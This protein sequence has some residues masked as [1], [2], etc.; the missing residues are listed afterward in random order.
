MFQVLAQAKKVN[1][2]DKMKQRSQILTG[3]FLEIIKTKREIDCICCQVV[4]ALNETFH[5]EHDKCARRIQSSLFKQGCI[6]K[7]VLIG[8]HKTR[9]DNFL[10]QSLRYAAYKQFIWWVFKKL[11]KGNRRVIPSCTLWK[12]KELYAEADKN[13]VM[14]LEGKQD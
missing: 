10:N 14:H 2:R 11:G 6:G 9:G 3:I 12:I 13:Y 8:L 5:N 4:D 1:L 7:N